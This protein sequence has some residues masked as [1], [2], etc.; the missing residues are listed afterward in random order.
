MRVFLNF[1]QKFISPLQLLDV[2]RRWKTMYGFYFIWINFYTL[3]SQNMSEKM[4]FRPAKV[5][6]LEINGDFFQ[7]NPF[8]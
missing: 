8:E 6:F 4:H 7:V 3:C 2:P 1:E 5:Y